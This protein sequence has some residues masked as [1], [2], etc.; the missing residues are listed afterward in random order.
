MQP[1]S[2]R[3]GPSDL[4][5][6]AHGPDHLEQGPHPV[7]MLRP[8]PSRPACRLTLS[9]HTKP[10]RAA[11]ARHAR[12]CRR[13]RVAGP[14]CQGSGLLRLASL[15]PPPS[16][17]PLTSP[18]SPSGRVSTTSPTECPHIRRRHTHFI[19]TCT[20]LALSLYLFFSLNSPNRLSRLAGSARQD[21]PTMMGGRAAP[22]RPAPLRGPGLPPGPLGYQ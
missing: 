18:P 2:V 12:S 7:R 1:P 10:A 13:Q 4:E 15:P 5:L 9:P 11:L 8:R 17:H 22:A 21:R 6:G 3:A 16:P 14:P 20:K 19:H